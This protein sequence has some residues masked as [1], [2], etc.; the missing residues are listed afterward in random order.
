MSPYSTT[1]YV[2]SG[3]GDLSPQNKG[4]FKPFTASA[5]IKPQGGQLNSAYEQG[6]KKSNAPAF[7]AGAN[8]LGTTQPPLPVLENPIPNQNEGVN[9]FT[10]RTLIGGGDN[11]QSKT[12]YNSAGLDG[13]GTAGGIFNQNKMSGFG[14]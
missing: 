14:F 5:P 12:N 2:N 4:I 1:E 7:E 13:F 11:T 9:P 10:G 6:A 8:S 3:Q